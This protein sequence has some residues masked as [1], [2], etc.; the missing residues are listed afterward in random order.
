MFHII[1]PEKRV[2]S[3]DTIEKWFADA[4]ANDEIDLRTAGQTVLDHALALE[5]IGFI[6]LGDQTFHTK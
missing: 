3:D 5:D 4:V 1:W 6:T 2:V